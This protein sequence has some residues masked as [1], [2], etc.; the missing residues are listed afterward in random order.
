MLG[1]ERDYLMINHSYQ[2]ESGCDHVKHVLGLD[3]ATVPYNHSQC[4][5]FMHHS[6]CV[7]Q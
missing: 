5:Q 2:H 4:T 6:V 1:Q 3:P 7:L